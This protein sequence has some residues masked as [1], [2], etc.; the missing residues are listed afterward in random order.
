MVTP[1]TIVAFAPIVAPRQTRVALN[2]CL[3]SM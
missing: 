1:Q 2:S 3:R